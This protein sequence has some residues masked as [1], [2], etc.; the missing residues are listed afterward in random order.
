[1]P[2]QATAMIPMMM[3]STP[4]TISDVDVDLNM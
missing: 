4:R 1:M 3:A 2:G